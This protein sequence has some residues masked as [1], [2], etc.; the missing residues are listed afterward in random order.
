MQLARDADA[1]QL[2]AALLVCVCD[3][4]DVLGGRDKLLVD[5][6]VMEDRHRDPA[7]LTEAKAR[8]RELLGCT[9]KHDAVTASK[10][11]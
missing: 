8:H 3:N 11:V 7:R 9:A 6:V 4:V 2:D 1:E 10:F 5:L